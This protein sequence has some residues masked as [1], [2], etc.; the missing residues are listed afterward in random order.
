MTIERLEL[1]T[2]VATC[3]VPTVVILVGLV[4]DSICR[5][6]DAK[7]LAAIRAERHSV[8]QRKAAARNK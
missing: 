1:V 8:A 4:A 6:R 5:W 2:L 3:G 7:E